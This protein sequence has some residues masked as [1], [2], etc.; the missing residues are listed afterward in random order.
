VQ[1]RLG[2]HRWMGGGKR[3]QR[4]AQNDMQQTTGLAFKTRLAMGFAARVVRHVFTAR[5]INRG[6]H[7]M[8]LTQ[9]RAGLSRHSYSHAAE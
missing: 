7:A 4:F 9:H 1:E 5:H 3:Q 8:F 2:I 6:M